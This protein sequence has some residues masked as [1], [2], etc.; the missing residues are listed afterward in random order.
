VEGGMKLTKRGDG[1][2][3]LDVTGQVCP[4]PEVYTIK[5]AEKL[6]MGSRLEVLITDQCS[7]EDLVQALKDRGF[8]IE[9]STPAP[10]VT[11]LKIQ[12]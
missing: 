8:S 7:L 2:Y 1:S 4:Y 10:G 3:V 9:E 5:V 11:S 6:K 12:T